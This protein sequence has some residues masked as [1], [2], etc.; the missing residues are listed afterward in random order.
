M[1][2][3]RFISC[4]GKDPKY[5]DN[6]CSQRSESRQLTV[7]FPLVMGHASQERWR[8]TNIPSSSWYDSSQVLKGHFCK[9]APL[10]PCEAQNKSPWLSHWV[11][12]S[13]AEGHDGSGINVVPSKARTFQHFYQ[14]EVYLHVLVKD[15]Q[16]QPKWI[17]EGGCPVMDMVWAEPKN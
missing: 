16:W 6:L 15:G 9:Q 17:Q 2:C 10:S 5:P 7:Y 11:P 1:E 8:L 3:K 12:E 14:A 4:S 13:H